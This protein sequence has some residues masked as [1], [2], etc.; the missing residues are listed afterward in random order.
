[1]ASEKQL[2]ANRANAKK[3]TGPKTPA[4]K[5]RSSMNAQRHGLSLP[6][7][8]TPETA[9][10]AAVFI[11]ALA[12]KEG[13]EEAVSKHAADFAQAQLDIERVQSVREELMA[14]L[15][16]D[17]ELPILR[18]LAALD[19]WERYALTRRRRAGRKLREATNLPVISER[20]P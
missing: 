5:L 10:K 17:P 1:M 20:I 6:L 16:L 3:S 2:A 8:L 7:Q 18:R 19:R 4:G 13:G 12:G 15:V 11:Q 9:A 14:N